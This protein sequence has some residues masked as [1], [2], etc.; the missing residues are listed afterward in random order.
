MCRVWLADLY[1]RFAPLTLTPRSASQTTSSPSSA[2][3]H[4]SIPTDYSDTLTLPLPRRR[5]A[6]YT[7]DRRARVKS[8]PLIG[9]LEPPFACSRCHEFM[10]HELFRSGSSFWLFA[11]SCGKIWGI[12]VCLRPC[13]WAQNEFSS[14]QSSCNMNSWHR[15][16]ANGGSRRPIS[17]KDFTLA[18]RSMGSSVNPQR[19]FSN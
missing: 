19:V 1:V 7:M 12:K 15:E 17:G 10:L 14:H 5:V 18:R 4:G 2:V 8:F 9:F 6:R 16:H 13:R 3:G 11:Y